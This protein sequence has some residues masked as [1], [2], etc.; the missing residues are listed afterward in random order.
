MRI[1]GEREK[2][3]NSKPTLSRWPARLDVLQSASGLL[4]AIF[5]WVHLCLESSILLGKDAMYFIARLFEGEPIFGRPYPLIVSAIVAI[6]FTLVV[7][8]S[9]LALR[10]FPADYQSYQAL[11]Q[12]MGRLRHTDT[13]LWYIQFTT[14]F[15]LFF[16]I[17]VHLYQIFMHPAS[18]G[19]FA[20]ADR[21]WSDRLWPLYLVLLVTVILHANI[22]FYRLAIKWHW[23]ANKDG[24]QNRAML[25]RTCVAASV[26]FLCLGLLTLS[27]YIKIGIEHSPHQ[28]ERYEPANSAHSM[29]EDQ[30]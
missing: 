15:V 18:I 14:G 3:D 13:T 1:M 29:V 25:L 11:R 30:P 19:P 5:V 9:V 4:L 27:I 12:H 10:K 16:I 8:H 24:I 26:F 23:F 22:G 7:V 2:L 17:L 6:I 21:I 28:G 20:S